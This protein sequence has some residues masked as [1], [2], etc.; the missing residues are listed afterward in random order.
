M[1][2]VLTYQLSAFQY[3]S[4]ISDD[5]KKKSFFLHNFILFCN[6]GDGRENQYGYQRV[7]GTIG[8]GITAFLGGAGMDIWSGEGV[9]NYKPA[10]L[11]VLA[12][13]IFDV[14]CCTKLKV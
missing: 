7:W 3:K 14:A 13:T 4:S 1:P 8:F 12:F 9:K 2:F 6:L 10:F 5:E 11:I